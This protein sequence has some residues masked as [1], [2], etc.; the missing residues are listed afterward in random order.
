MTESFASSS[1]QTG[2]IRPS[3][4]PAGPL[5][6]VRTLGC[7]VNQVES[8]GILATL[9]GQ[10]VRLA[11]EHLAALILINTCTVTGEADR[12]A[13]KA[14]RHALSQPQAPLV[15]VTGCLAS[16][17]A[18]ALESLGDRVVIEADKQQIPAT[19]ARLLAFEPVAHA[20]VL[21]A[22]A[23]FHT[24]AMLKV[25]DGCDNHCT[26]CIVPFAR[27]VP[28]SEPMDS[29]LTEARSLVAAGTSEIVV[30][31]INVGR[32]HDP[33]SGAGLAELLR[34]LA[35][36]GVDRLRLS[37]I[38]PQDLTTELL[39]VIASLPG[40]CPH[41]HVPLQSGSD[42]VLS[43]MGRRYTAAEYL[44]RVAAAKTALPGLTL[45]TDVL[46]GF[47]GED[48]RDLAATLALC[49]HVAFSKIHVFRYSRRPGTPAAQMPDQLSPEVL[50]AHA[51]EVRQLA[52]E[53]RTQWLDGLIGTSLDVLVEKQRDDG[54]IEGTSAQY[55]KVRIAQVPG[56]A[57]RAGSSLSVMIVGRDGGLLLGDPLTGDFAPA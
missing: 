16:I 31:G 33:D 4:P 23:E 9:V 3:S 32:Y 24:R 38:E 1:T 12:K 36:T 26:Y 37:S 18:Q 7:K 42:K 45:T 29:L 15:L 43:A 40:F 20:H 50:A 30:T 34:A 56:G 6:A 53:L 22:G 35:G 57:P 19:V 14:V 41:L 46:V 13:R 17:D 11:E 21:R 5:I 54:V 27:G 25:E 28:R 55:A 39:G 52:E 47:P 44:D 51:L 10:G 8:E 48:A 49:R 2:Q